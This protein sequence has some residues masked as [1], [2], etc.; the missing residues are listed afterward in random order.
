MEAVTPVEKVVDYK[1]KCLDDMEWGTTVGKVYECYAELYDP[2]TNE[3]ILIAIIDDDN[4][5]HAVTP[6]F[7]EKVA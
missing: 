6:D 2:D 4:D 3:L 1:V 5:E 7:F